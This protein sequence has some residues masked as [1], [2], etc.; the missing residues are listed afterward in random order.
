MSKKEVEIDFAEIDRAIERHKARKATESKIEKTAEKVSTAKKPSTARNTPKKA[1]NKG[2]VIAVKVLTKPPE[3]KENPK[4]GRFMDFVQTPKFE[5]VLSATI[6]AAVAPPES[7]EDDESQNITVETLT[8]VSSVDLAGVA[9]A[10]KSLDFDAPL[11]EI[12][13][14]VPE[15]EESEEAEEDVPEETI[16]EEPI[17]VKVSA[18]APVDEHPETVGDAIDAMEDEEL[19]YEGL[20]EIAAM[21]PEIPEEDNFDADFGVD[22]IDDLTLDSFIETPKFLDK[23]V[24]EKRPL[25]GGD[26]VEREIYMRELLMA[27]EAVSVEEI[28]DETPQKALVD[29]TPNERYAKRYE[30]PPRQ[31]EKPQVKDNFKVQSKKEKSSVGFYIILILLLLI[32]GGTAGALLYFSGVFTNLLG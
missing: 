6:E 20:D 22:S 25:G 18:S 24:V 19:E 32:L 15:V 23:V 16:E 1:D 26:P 12:S 30:N 27:E 8:V 14:S 31:V 2:E 28:V 21:A 13:P 7:L 3:P 29:D 10:L 9:D 17:S 4:E 5:R 11:S